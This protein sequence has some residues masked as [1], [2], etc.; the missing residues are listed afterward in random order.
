MKK[1]LC[2]M[3]V[4]AI[5]ATPAIGQSVKSV[6]AASNG[7]EVTVYSDD[8]ADRHEYSAP[9]VKS[10]SNQGFVLVAKVDKAATK[11]A[12]NLQGT[13]IYSGD[14]RFYN[15]AIFKGGTAVDFTSTSRDVGRCHSSRYS[16]PSC[17]LS[18][19][20]HITITPA[21]IKQFSANGVLP[22]Q[23]RAS[24][25]ADTDMFEIPVSYFDAVAEVA[26]KK[27]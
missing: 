21:Q 26:A 8:F 13:F 9:S 15:N 22:I 3:A 25:T 12:V 4:A 14:W 7:V 20:F 5:F 16:R 1:L 6:V 19:S 17:T 10:S 11:G 27:R 23:V 24:K 2:G 18:E